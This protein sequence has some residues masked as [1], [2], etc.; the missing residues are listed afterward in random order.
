[1]HVR[2]RDGASIWFS[3]NIIGNLYMS[4][5]MSAAGAYIEAPGM[6]LKGFDMYHRLLTAYAKLQAQK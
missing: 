5:R 6:A 2:E 3:V 1:M 4:N